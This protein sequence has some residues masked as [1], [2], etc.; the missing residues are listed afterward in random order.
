MHLHLDMFLIGSVPDGL[1]FL[2]GFLLCP[3][4]KDLGLSADKASWQPSST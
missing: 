1:A 4:V 3:A 2:S